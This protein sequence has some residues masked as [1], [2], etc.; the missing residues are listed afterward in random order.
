MHT[1]PKTNPAAEALRPRSNNRPPQPQPS[2]AG[3]TKLCP[4]CG[5]RKATSAFPRL[6]PGEPFRIKI[7]C[8][9]CERHGGAE[10][11]RE[12]QRQKILASHPGHKFCVRC[13]ALKPLA[14]YADAVRG[15]LC[16]ACR[17]AQRKA[18]RAEEKKTARREAWATPA[19]RFII[20]LALAHDTC[21]PGH[22]RTAAEIAAY[23]GCR[24][25]VIRRIEERALEKVLGP[26]RKILRK[27]E[28]HVREVRL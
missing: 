8:R 13:H 4:G 28:M 20:G 23:C 3:K 21:P 15:R 11:R 9:S 6:K 27:A 18:R 5:L 24:E 14:D 7:R 1:N 2:P 12:A 22:R 26:L 19:E 25:A 16:R 17:E 10:R